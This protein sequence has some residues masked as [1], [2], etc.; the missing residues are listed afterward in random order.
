MAFKQQHMREAEKLALQL[1]RD[2]GDAWA[3]VECL[4]LI[5]ER[6][7]NARADELLPSMTTLQ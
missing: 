5:L 3:V 7:N 2:L 6:A 4:A 1:P